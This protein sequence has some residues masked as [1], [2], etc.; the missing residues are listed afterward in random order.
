MKIINFSLNIIA[1]ATILTSCK[2]V[3]SDDTKNSIKNS[4]SNSDVNM[5]KSRYLKTETETSYD[6]DSFLE[7]IDNIGLLISKSINLI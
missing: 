4:P 1:F 7:D 3:S 2:F 6:D 5:M